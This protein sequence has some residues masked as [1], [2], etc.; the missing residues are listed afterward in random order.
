MFAHDTPFTFYCSECWWSDKWD[1]LDYGKSYDF[2]SPFF[3]QFGKLL[4]TVPLLNMWAFKN[5]NS[6]Y[7][8]YG[9]NDKNAYLSYAVVSGEDICY[10]DMI[11]Q[12]RNCFDCYWTRS[13]EL[14]FECHDAIDSYNSRFLLNSRSCV[15]S[16]FLFDCVNCQNCFMCSNL[17]GKSYYIRNRPY[18]RNDYLKEIKKIQ[19]N[20]WKT[21]QTLREEFV[22]LTRNALHK[23][24]NIAN[25]SFSS[26]DNLTNTKNVHDSFYTDNAE[27]LNHC[28]WTVRYKDSQ[29]VSGSLDSELMYEISVGALNNYFSKFF[30]HCHSGRYLEYSYF[31]HSCSDCFACIGLRNKQYCILNKQYTK[32]EYESLIPKIKEHMNT[33]PYIDKQG[34]TYTYG[35]F[36]PPELSPF[37][38][39]ETIAQEYFPLTKEEALARG[40]RWKDPEVKEYTVTKHPED[41]PDDIGSIDDSIFNE[42]IGCAHKGTCLHQCTTA[43][44]IIPEELSFYQRMHLPLPRLCPNCRHYERLSQRNPLKLWKRRCMCLS[45]ESLAKKDG[46]RNTVAHFHGNTPCQNEFETPYAPDRAETIYCEQ[47]YQT[48]VI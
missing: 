25:T 35:E 10:S 48:E 11:H 46:H 17:R 45:S 30:T 3:S 13:S 15:E 37:A 22:A 16:W 9:T 8:N 7:M 19:T 21:L 20:S 2:S 32:E 26:G 29:D 42:T 1:P 28:W 23:F 41:L 24:A 36:F 6:E 4:K 18:S 33:M 44:R 43:F 38:Y 12:S 39:N 27:N 47:C 5:T 31:C 40:Y 14:C 34:R